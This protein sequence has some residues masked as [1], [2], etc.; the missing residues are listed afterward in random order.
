[1]TRLSI[2]KM[3]RVEAVAEIIARSHG[4]VMAE[5]HG[6]GEFPLHALSEPRAGRRPHPRAVEYIDTARQIIAR[7]GKRDMR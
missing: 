4:F 7:L 5:G 3:K 1:M 2:L 6:E